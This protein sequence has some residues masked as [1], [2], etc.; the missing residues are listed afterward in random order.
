MA[1]AIQKT[2]TVGGKSIGESRSIATVGDLAHEKS[3]AAAKVGTL[4][5]RTDN[6][7]GSLTMVTGHAI[8]T[9]Q[10]LDLYW[11]EAGVLKHRRGV[12]AGVVAG[13]VVPIDLGAGDNLPPAAHTPINVMVATQVDFRVD[14]DEVQGFS[15]ACTGR[16]QIVFATAANAE[17]AAFVLPIAGLARSWFK[18]DGSVNPLAGQVVDRL[19]VSHGDN[20]SAHVIKVG[21]G[22]N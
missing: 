6:D 19:F 5:I 15:V 16:A 1:I 22:Y 17:I 12:V 4:T 9:G 10:R 13:D 2:I 21:L 8:T 7:T 18:D 20:L 3:Y 11:A 14:G